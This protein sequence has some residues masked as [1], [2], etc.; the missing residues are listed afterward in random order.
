MLCEG[1]FYFSHEI[2]IGC[3]TEAAT[4]DLPT[5]SFND[6]IIQCVFKTGVYRY[7]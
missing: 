7:I 1:L 2:R 4:I 3:F 6:F 5:F